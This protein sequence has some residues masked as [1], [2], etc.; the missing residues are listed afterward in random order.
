MTA[1]RVEV[2]CACCGGT[3]LHQ[4][5]ALCHACYQ[6]HHE[7][8]TLHKYPQLHTWL[9][10][11]ARIADFAELRGRGLSVRRASAALGVTARSGQR[12]EQRLKARQA[13][14]S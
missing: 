9:E 7:N 8:G 4:G 11:L 13:V 14:T 2:E 12:Y 6:W 10:T 5:R 1:P 3:G